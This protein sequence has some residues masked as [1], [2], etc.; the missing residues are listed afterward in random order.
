KKDTFAT[1]IGFITG[2]L[3]VVWPWKIKTYKTDEA[4]NFLMDSHG[5]KVIDNYNRFFPDFTSG[6]T[7][8]AIFFI[9]VGIFIVL[10]LALYEKRAHAKKIARGP[11]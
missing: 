7:Y 2:S 5:G 9:L 3:G 1:I 4:G 8:L 6:E 11:K 10:G